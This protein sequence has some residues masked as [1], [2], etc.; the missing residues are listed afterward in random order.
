MEIPHQPEKRKEN[1]EE[2]KEKKCKNIQHPVKVKVIMQMMY[3]IR[4]ALHTSIRVL[5]NFTTMM[6][7]F[8]FK[9]F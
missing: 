6:Q 5:V 3:E 7:H 9:H 1:E 4:G 8:I 2:R